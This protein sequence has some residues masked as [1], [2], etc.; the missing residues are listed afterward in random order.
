MC[1]LGVQRLRAHSSPQGV[2]Q[3]ECT[4]FKI[5]VQ[6]QRYSGDSALKFTK[7][8]MYIQIQ[9]RFFANFILAAPSFARL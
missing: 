2:R 9:Q 6:S 3:T 4:V 7:N 8:C 1:V 5:P